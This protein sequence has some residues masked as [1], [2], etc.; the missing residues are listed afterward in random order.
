MQPFNTGTP[1][2]Q[3]QG[4]SGTPMVDPRGQQQR[5]GAKNEKLAYMLYALGG[6][7]RGDKNFVQNTL[8]LQQMEE[9][10]KKK[11]AQK[12]AFDEF[13]G[14][15]EGK[16]DPR[17]TD[18]AKVLGPEKGSEIVMR[19]FVDP[20]DTPADILKLE[21]VGILR[22]RLDPSSPNY[23][24]SYTLEQFNQDISVLGVTSKALEKTKKQFIADYM[25]EGRKA[26]TFSG[27]KVY[28]DEELKIMA[29]KAYNMVYGGTEAPAPT[30]PPVD[31]KSQEIIELNL[32]DLG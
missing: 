25:K 23:D 5:R 22:S 6:A 15:Y 27:Q 21:K 18:F 31:E 30:P 12:K 20:E 1:F 26:K 9:G 2:A 32:D 7:L 10:K 11:E 3:E 4:V 28:S 13:L 16:I 14:K 8:A 17:I 19:E 29:E 24:S